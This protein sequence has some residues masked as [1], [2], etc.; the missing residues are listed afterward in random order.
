MS[1]HVA[2]QKMNVVSKEEMTTQDIALW[3]EGR[4]YSS[5]SST[6]L[7]SAAVFTGRTFRYTD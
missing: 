6:F 2:K 3:S 1:L 5:D 7:A 4:A